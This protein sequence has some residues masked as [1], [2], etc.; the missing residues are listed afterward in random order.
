MR[1]HE[2][3]HDAKAAAKG[4]MEAFERLY[5]RHAGRVRRVAEWTLGSDDVG[6]VVQDAFLRVWQK[7][8]SFRGDASFKTWLD[9]VAT[10][11]FLRARERERRRV[12]RHVPLDTGAGQAPARS[13]RPDVRID[14][15]RA[16]DLLPEGARLVF[17]LHDVQGMRHAEV[18]ERLGITTP[19]S[20]SQLH[21]ARMILREHLDGEPS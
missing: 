7:L 11:V 21:R 18:A 14:I 20:R 9:R 6:D 12:G 15:E 19:T 10:R 16:V 4:D 2:D 5:A 8:G 1:C 17:V 13:D 3:H